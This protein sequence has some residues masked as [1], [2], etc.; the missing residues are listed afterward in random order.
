M[1][2]KT[3]SKRKNMASI[4]TGSLFLVLLIITAP[5]EVVTLST[6]TK[7]SCSRRDIFAKAIQGFSVA[8]AAVI[9]ATKAAHAACLPGDLS[10]DCIGVYKIPFQAAIDS[11]MLNTEEALKKNAPDV[12][13]LKTEGP[14]KSVLVAKEV[15]QTQRVAAEDI[16]A[17]ILAGKLEEAGIKVLNLIPKVTGA[18]MTIQEQVQRQY[19][20]SDS[21]NN[22]MRVLKYQQSF[23][24]M[25][26]L[27]S[28]VDVEIGQAIRGQLGVSAVAQLAILRSLKEAIAAFD[29][30]MILVE[31]NTK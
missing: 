14:P 13:Y 15:L 23:Q 31:A 5:Q 4:S 17:V 21:G 27:W 9:P 20:V 12:K 16:Q 25:V 8:A 26:A 22:Q 10:P 29:D 18:G 19:P 3:N 6:N 30:F 1:A 11:P 2:T 24:E 28:G 7:N